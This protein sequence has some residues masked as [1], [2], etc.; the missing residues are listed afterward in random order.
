M[1]VILESANEEYLY[2][3]NPIVAT[4]PVSISAWFKLTANDETVVCISDPI[5]GT[6]YRELGV[7]ASDNTHALSVESDGEGSDGDTVA[8]WSSGTW[9]FAVAVF[10]TSTS[11]TIYLND[12]DGGGQ[13]NENNPD[14]LTDFAIG[15]RHD[16]T[17]AKF[18][19]GSIAEVAVWDM[20]LSGADVASLYA[21]GAGTP[22]TNVQSGNLV[23]YWPLISGP[24]ATV[25]TNL[26]ENG[27]ISYNAGDHPVTHAAAGDVVT[28][29]GAYELA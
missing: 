29:T 14:N 2:V 24:T 28:I 3:V 20:A 15:R 4:L 11:R 19:N 13:T 16:L 26:S 17:P 23:G 9:F 1:S 21:S 27:T 22:A 10:A 18:C 6:D 12:T 8:G 25:G 5:T 7:N